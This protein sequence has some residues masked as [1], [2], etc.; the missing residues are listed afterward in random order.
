VDPA[1][2]KARIT[3]VESLSHDDLPLEETE[4]L[5]VTH[6]QLDLVR[7]GTLFVANVEDAN[8]VY[9]EFVVFG[10]HVDNTAHNLLDFVVDR[11]AKLIKL[12]EA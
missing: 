11:E 2:V 7:L 3:V 5:A 4:A 1:H 10:G 8:T 12:L 9:L 6:I